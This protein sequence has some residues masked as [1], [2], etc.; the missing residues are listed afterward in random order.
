MKKAVLPVTIGIA[1]LTISLIGFASPSVQNNDSKKQAASVNSQQQKKDAPAPAATAAKK[2]VYTCPMHPD[3]KQDKPGKCPKC[4]MNLEKKETTKVTYTCPMHQEIT[5]EK[6]G[7]CPKCGM[8]M[9]EKKPSK[10]GT[11]K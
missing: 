7:K 11:P 6:P 3:V 9:V 5:K 2:D 8:D 10:A 1:I 4:N